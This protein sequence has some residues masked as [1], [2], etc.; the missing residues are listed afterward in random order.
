MANTAALRQKVELINGLTSTGAGILAALVPGTGAV[1]AA[2]KVCKDIYELKK[3]VDIHNAWVDSMEV[4]FAAQSG[5]AAAV[6]NTLKNAKIHLDHSKVSLVLHTAQA[7]AAVAQ[8]MDPSGVSSIV[9]A[10]LSMADAL[11]EFGYKMHNEVVI[12]KGWNAYKDAREDPRN[13]KRAREALRLNSTLAKCCIAYGASIM[14]DPSAQQAIRA[15]GLTVAALQN[16][17]DICNKL[18]NYLENE[19]KGD[20]EILRVVNTKDS[21]W[22]P[23]KPELT[24]AS[25]MAFKG[26]ASR[27]AEPLLAP[28]SAKTPGLDRLLSELGK[29]DGW[30]DKSTFERHK[31]NYEKVTNGAPEAP[32]PATFQTLLDANT[33]AYDLLQRATSAFGSYTPVRADQSAAKHDGME[34]VGASFAT[35]ARLGSVTVSINLDEI[36]GYIDLHTED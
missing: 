11:T 16:D 29:L 23:G 30:Q 19:L 6:Q 14:G 5:V 31:S 3:C 25:W 10:S 8:V 27:N 9:S 1:V 4:A 12:T 21:K 24:M 36:Q 15:T 34:Q 7:G 22:H 13:R 32:F 33:A 18:V 17:K 2:Q 35:L 20:P 26:A 28:E